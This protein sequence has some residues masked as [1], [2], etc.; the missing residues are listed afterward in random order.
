MAI[1]SLALRTTVFTATTFANTQWRNGATGRVKTMEVSY[2]QTS[3]TAGQIG[4]GVPQALAGTPTDVLFQR[5]DPGDP[6]SLCIGS[7]AFTTSPTVPLIYKRRWTGAAT[8]GVGIIWTFPR[9]LG[10]AISSANVLWNIA[11]TAASDVNMVI[12]E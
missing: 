5:D 7:I 11:T 12:D 6:A 1:S 10:M 8:A 4:L 9:A 3:A 2:I